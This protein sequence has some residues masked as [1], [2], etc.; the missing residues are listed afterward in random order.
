M[1][2]L[3]LFGRGH[4]WTGSAKKVNGKWVIRANS[5]VEGTCAKCGKEGIPGLNF[6]TPHYVETIKMLK[7]GGLLE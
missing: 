7:E 1:K 5:K 3:D 6:C 2:L 4:V